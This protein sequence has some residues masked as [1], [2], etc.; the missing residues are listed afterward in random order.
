MSQLAFFRPGYAAAL[1]LHNFGRAMII[2]QTNFLSSKKP[3]EKYSPHWN[4]ACRS[5]SY[6]KSGEGEDE[7]EASVRDGR[8]M[9]TVFKKS[10]GSLAKVYCNT[11]QYNVD[12]F[13]MEE[14]PSNKRHLE[15]SLYG[16]KQARDSEK[17]IGSI[18][19][20]IER[21]TMHKSIH[22]KNLS[23][24]SSFFI[25]PVKRLGVSGGTAPFFE[26]V[27][28]DPPINIVTEESLNSPTYYVGKD[29]S[30]ARDELEFYELIH[31]L[32]K[33]EDFKEEIQD[34]AT[35][36]LDYA[37]V[38]NTK[39]AGDDAVSVLGNLE[40]IVMQNLRDQ[41]TKLRLLDLKI[42]HKTSA[43]GW[44][45]KSAFASKQQDILDAMT[46][47]KIEGFRLE[48]FDGMPKTLVSRNPLMD[49]HISSETLMKK[50]RRKSL[51]DMK[52]IDIFPYFTDLYDLTV[53]NFQIE[54]NLSR[55]EYAEIVLNEIVKKLT[56]LMIVCQKQTTYQKWIGSSVALG[57]DSGA[58][59]ARSKDEKEIRD[60]VIVKIFDWGRSTLNTPNRTKKL[61]VE[62]QTSHKWF[63]NSYT[64]GIQNLA[65]SA[66]HCYY[67]DYNSE[68][69]DELKIT[70]FDFDG[71]SSC[72]ILGYCTYPLVEL[73]ETITC[74]LTLGEDNNTRASQNS[75]GSISFR[76]KKTKYPEASRFKDGW[77]IQ[78]IG[79]KGLQD[80]DML[81]I[82][83]PYVKIC[84]QSGRKSSSR[85]TT[86]KNND[87]NP[88]WNEK[89][90]FPTVKSK[91]SLYNALQ[92]ANDD[93]MV[94]SY[95]V[96]DDLYHLCGDDYSKSFEKWKEKVLDN[97]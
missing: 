56:S 44:Q 16:V 6:G 73:D 41:K 2:G 46:N 30:R 95:D 84:V 62:E 94:S 8:F 5:F 90:E 88:V 85:V 60:Q 79:A 59:P 35:Y 37:G 93:R 50:S 92:S 9:L 1:K 75:L 24:D 70:V 81:D 57:F 67:H 89:F 48:G 80:K 72:D 28:K 7:V 17:H 61:S 20:K 87:L 22:A 42:G 21:T 45:G 55:E 53:E 39:E 54:E 38:L 14:G 47:S 26:L 3:A 4:Y 32:R 78:I 51:Q 71:V 64:S 58:L 10:K 96:E 18:F 36:F 66:A 83:D 34:L 27:L 43:P 91:A 69:W 19:I 25:T 82:S 68:S 23:V 15:L 74:D 12:E 40:L 49:I 11:K 52:G 76:A 65:W 13:L 97:E 63:W 29:L 31:Q 33:A 77:S 86:V